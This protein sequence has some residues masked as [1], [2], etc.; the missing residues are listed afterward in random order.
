M[1]GN[2]ISTSRPH[3]VELHQDATIYTSL[4]ASGQSVTHTLE[5]G[6]RAYVFVIDGEL[7]LNGQTLRAGDQARII[8][9]RELRLAGPSNGAAPADFLLLNL[10]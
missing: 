10:P 8:E 9:E 3:A 5:P 6:R 4:L 2:G 1:S 7:N